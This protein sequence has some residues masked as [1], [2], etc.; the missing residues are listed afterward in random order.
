MPDRWRLRRTTCRLKVCDTARQESCATPS[1]QLNHLGLI[2]IFGSEV[3]NLSQ[4]LTI[5]N[6]EGNQNRPKNRGLGFPS[7][8][9]FRNFEFLWML[10]LGAWMFPS[11]YQLERI[12][13]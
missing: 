5:P 10:A 2:E 9:D 13:F 12:S 4:D 3:S 6:L 11:P 7:G 1:G 8:F